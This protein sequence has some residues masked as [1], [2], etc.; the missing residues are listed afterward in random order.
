M[1]QEN[2]FSGV[3]FF[4]LLA[5]AVLGLN[6][7]GLVSPANALHLINN[8]GPSIILS[9]MVLILAFVLYKSSLNSFSLVKFSLLILLV[10][11][12]YQLG[13]DAGVIAWYMLLFLF[14]ITVVFFV[15]NFLLKKIAGI[16]WV[17]LL[18]NLLTILYLFLDQR[19]YLVTK[20]H[21]SFKLLIE[22]SKVAAL[23][24]D[25]SKHT[26]QQLLEVIFQTLYYCL[27]PFVGFILPCSRSNSERFEKTFIFASAVVLF[28]HFQLFSFVCRNVP[29]P[30]YLP[31]RLELGSLPVPLHP[32][33][34]KNKKMQKLIDQKIEINENKIYPQVSLAPSDDFAKPDIV[35]ILVE[36]LRR[37]EFNRYMP[38]CR[39][40]AGRGIN[41]T[42]HYSVSN[43]SASSFHSI[44]NSSFPINHAFRTIGKKPQVNF[45]EFLVENGYKTFLLKAAKYSTFPNDFRWGQQ[46]IEPQIEDKSQD[47]GILLKK[48]ADLLKKPGKKAVLV[49]FFNTHF[50]YYY[51]DE[52]EKFR[53]VLDSRANL[54]LINPTPD[55]VKKV[56]NRYKNA[57]A[58]TD[59]MLEKF[60][61]ELENSDAFSNT[62][63]LLMGDHGESLGEA[64][65]FAHSTG[66]HIYQ[67]AV[68]TF[69]LGAGIQP[70]EVKTPTT[71]SDVLPI[72]ANQTG[73]K[74]ENAWGQ[75]LQK[76]RS[77]PLLQIDES[78]TGRLIVRHE[79]F[80]SLFDLS[81]NGNLSWLATVANDYS[82]DKS[83]AHFYTDK[84]L[85]KLQQQLSNDI[86]FIKT[87][88]Q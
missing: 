80:M 51:P 62:I 7:L 49:Y 55:N 79:K 65:F 67:F 86:A 39:K 83:V 61:K 2:K 10:A 72:L 19:I 28:I 1:K 31:V 18:F 76:K 69:M 63:F 14:L 4:Q 70:E 68:P 21:I 13:A 42:D 32:A 71:H 50:N 59:A 22:L 43:I 75:S 3:V 84:S 12:I 20:T 64:G 58:Y 85:E 88:L 73:I 30:Y 8:T 27:L 15:Q 35:I 11:E 66:P 46:L 56:Q 25:S 77:Y 5:I 24:V 44:F 29:L 82:I 36:S 38:F 33:L 16:G 34:N 17:F 40:L 60:F 81:D 41:L 53:P 47:A 57:V 78:V 48:T 37:Q 52:Y 26:G 74:I 45:H 23:V 87:S 9:L 6:L 54:F